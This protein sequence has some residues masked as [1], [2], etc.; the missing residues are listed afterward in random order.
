[1]LVD[2][3]LGPRLEELIASSPGQHDVNVIASTYDSLT[4]TLTLF[5][6]TTTPRPAPPPRPPRP[7]RPGDGTVPRLPRER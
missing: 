3:R 5:L 2:K 7:P 1:M 6:E 4:D